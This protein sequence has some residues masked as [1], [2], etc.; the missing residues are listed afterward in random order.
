MGGSRG[1][2]ECEE[3]ERSGNWPSVIDIVEVVGCDCNCHTSDRNNVRG[4]FLDLQG[5]FS[6]K[7]EVLIV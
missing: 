5:C 2:R 3:G 4:C 7:V 6:G 1:G